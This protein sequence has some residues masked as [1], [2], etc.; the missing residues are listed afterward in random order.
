MVSTLHNLMVHFWVQWQ[1]DKAAWQAVL[2]NL[3]EILSWNWNHFWLKVIK[4]KLSVRFNGITSRFHYGLTP[5]PQYLIFFH[6][7]MWEFLCMRSSTDRKWKKNGDYCLLQLAF[8]QIIRKYF[9]LFQFQQ[10]FFIFFFFL[11]FFSSFVSLFLLLESFF[12]TEETRNFSKWFILL[13]I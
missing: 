11:F 3:D 4:I 1:H 10:L 7:F 2:M 5:L 8:N 9:H 6:F 13:T 12:I